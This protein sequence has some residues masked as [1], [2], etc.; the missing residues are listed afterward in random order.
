MPGIAAILATAICVA[1]RGRAWTWFDLSGGPIMNI[2]LIVLS[3]IAVA[4]W[5]TAAYAGTCAGEIDRMQ[6]RV[7]AKVEATAPVGRSAPE[8]SGA[9]LHHQPTPGS[10]AE[11]EA[12]VGDRSAS[13]MEAANAA[14]ARA[15][16]ADSRGD[17]SACERALAEV[18]RLIGP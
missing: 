3:A 2:G 1:G 14:I 18:Q 17:Q 10:L 4:A 8:S 15:R 5:T 12:R 11:A 16:Q 7:D 13:T 6:A 9:L